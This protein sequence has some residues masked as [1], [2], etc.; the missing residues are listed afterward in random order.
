MRRKTEEKKLTT[1]SFVCMY[2]G[3]K[4]E[5]LAFISVFSTHP[6]LSC[7]LGE[8]KIYN[9]RNCLTPELDA[10]DCSSFS[11]GGKLLLPV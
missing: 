2:V 1:V 3:G 11:P 10:V 9:Y 7:S 6:S 8:G 4:S 5:M